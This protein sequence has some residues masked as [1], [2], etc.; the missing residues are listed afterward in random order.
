LY[1]G[2][3][4]RTFVHKFHQRSLILFKLLL[5]VPISRISVSGDNFSEYFLFEKSSKM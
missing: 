1:V 4:A 5:L 3:S 2:L